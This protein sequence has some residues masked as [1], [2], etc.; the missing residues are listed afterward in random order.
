M[1]DS[2]KVLAQNDVND[3]ATTVC[4]P[5]TAKQWVISKAVAAN[6]DT[7]DRTLAV[8]ING[9]ASANMLVPART[10]PTGATWIIDELE[11][12]CLDTADTVQMIASSTDKIS[13]TIFGVERD[14]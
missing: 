2:Y 13:V 5:P 12:A 3:T 4:D 8:Y 11:G 6:H 1:A 9:S 7:V 10:V 14:A